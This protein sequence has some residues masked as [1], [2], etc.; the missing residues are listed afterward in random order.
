MFNLLL[1][2]LGIS[3]RLL[4]K[5]KAIELN[6]CVTLFDILLLI[7][8]SFTMFGQYTTGSGGRH[9]RIV[10]KTSEAE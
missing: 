2:L 3:I 9:G 10:S 5:S 6:A 1:T 8:L 7:I 4:I